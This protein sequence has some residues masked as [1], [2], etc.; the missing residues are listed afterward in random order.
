MAASTWPALA[1]AACLA[2]CSCNSVLGW[3]EA[4]PDPLGQLQ[5]GGLGGSAGAAGSEGTGGTGGTA[6][7]DGTAGSGGTGGTGGPR[8]TQLSCQL[9]CADIMKNCQGK[10]LEYGSTEVCMSM[11]ALLEPGFPGETSA[12]TLAC[13][14][15]RAI[16]AA[17]D[18]AG[19]CAAAG[20]LGGGVCGASPCDAFCQ[21]DLALCSPVNA[22][23]YPDFSTCRDACSKFTVDLEAGDLGLQIG[24]TFNCRNYHLQNAFSISAEVHCPHT[25]VVSE[26]CN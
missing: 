17:S 6:G 7:S 1:A 2:L 16:S 23:P 5:V 21:F 9:Y 25:G 18:P 20:P 12:N 19:N 4:S 3:D 13:R 24:D 8:G 10:L 22:A 11:C 15:L 14:Q 26:T